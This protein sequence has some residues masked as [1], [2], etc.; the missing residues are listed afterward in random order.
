M[1]FPFLIDLLEL[2][3][4]SFPRPGSVIAEYQL[5]FVMPEEHQEQLRNF[6]LSREMVYNVL[7]QF[8]YDQEGRGAS[9]SS[10]AL[11]IDPVSLK[12]S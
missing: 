2:V 7:R 12:L 6:T 10:S 5:T 4:S 8:L 1:G 11:Y 3:V 9:P